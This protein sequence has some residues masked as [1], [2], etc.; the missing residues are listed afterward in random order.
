MFPKD[1]VMK[2]DSTRNCRL[3]CLCVPVLAFAMCLKVQTSAATSSLAE[4]LLSAGRPLV[5][6]HRGYSQIAPENTLPSFRL[7]KSAGAD[8]VE[9]DY[10]HTKDGLPVVIHDYDLDRTT[11]AVARWGGKKIR[12][13]S[14]TA[15]ELRFLDAGKWFSRQFTGTHL[16]R[17]G[18]ALELIQEGGVTLI[19]RK[20]G[21]AATLL[22]LLRSRKLVNQ[23][24]VQSF[25]W[26]FLK[27]FHEQVP[28]QILGALGPPSTRDGK[29]LSDAEKVLNATWIAEAEKTGARIIGWSRLVTRDAVEQ[30]HARGLKVWIYTV[31]EPAL[32]NQLIDCGVDGIIS[33]NPALIW[34][35]VALRGWQAA[36]AR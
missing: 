35:T 19:E 8:L 36:P 6:A 25:D 24:I 17:L 29:K 30:A 12:V 32:A 14:K 4:R 20:T 3:L 15:A 9:L 1:A 11:D 33:D 27:D 13:D 7:A 16:P 26:T 18:E 10:Q 31:N 5:I 34:R 21:D 22:K 23:L 2:I 28:Q